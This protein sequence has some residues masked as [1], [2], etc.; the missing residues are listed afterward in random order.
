M[1]RKLIS[2]VTILLFSI[3]IFAQNITIDGNKSDWDN[4][5]ILSEPGEFPFVKVHVSGDSLLY[6]MQLSPAAAETS[7]QQINYAS[8]NVTIFPNPERGFYKHTESTLG[9]SGTL[10]ETVLRSYMNNEKISIILRVYYLTNFRAAPL[11]ATAL[12]RFDTDMDVLRKSGLKCILRFAYTNQ[13]PGEDAPL[14]IVKQHLDQLAPYFSKHADV[15]AFMQAGFA[16]P[17]GEWHSS[18]NNLNTPAAS[19]EILNKILQH[20]PA[21]RMVQVRTPFY[22]QRFLDRKTALNKNEAFNKSHVARIGHHND[23]FMGSIN[24]YGTYK[25]IME[26]KAY[27]NTECLFV[28]SGGETCPPSGI[29]PADCTKAQQEM[30]YL[31]WTYLNDGY[32]R[33]VNDQWIVQGCMDNI[34]REMGYCFQLKSGIFSRV[35]APGSAFS[36]RIV[37]KNIG[38]APVYNKRDVELILK[39]NQSN[40]VYY[41]KLNTDPRF[42]EP[43]TENLV[44]VT[45][46]IPADIQTGSYSLYLN[47]PD[48]YESLAGRP[49]YS[50]RM[51]NQQIWES[52]TGYNNLKVNINIENDAEGTSYSGNKYFSLK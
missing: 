51:A 37:I 52:T 6:M 25:D 46:G 7:I 38:Y 1:I 13:M 5:P 34:K 8:D 16:G 14:E 21:E 11:N 47:L 40:A 50:I 42:W 12:Q 44:D 22:K 18:S 9:T 10:N 29:D 17:W 36:A 31:R 27:M 41:V 49:E 15:I 35:I 28:P 4:V 23:C 33:G 26:D 19:S 39:N 3:F 20:L 2:S 43:Q 45:A 32:Y 48:A 30:R 24:D